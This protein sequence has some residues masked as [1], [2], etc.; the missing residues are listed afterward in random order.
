MTYDRTS[1]RLLPAIAIRAPKFVHPLTG[2]LSF[3]PQ[4][5]AVA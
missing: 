4:R 5:Q 2:D 3:Q 1:L